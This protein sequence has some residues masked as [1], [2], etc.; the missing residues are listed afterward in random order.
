MLSCEE[1]DLVTH[2]LGVIAGVMMACHVCT[3]ML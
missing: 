1:A 2:A 3:A